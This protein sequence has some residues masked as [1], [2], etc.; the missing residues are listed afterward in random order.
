MIKIVQGC[1]TLEAHYSFLLIM[2]LFDTTG[3][4]TGTDTNTSIGSSHK[5]R[6]RYISEILTSLQILPNLLVKH[7][8]L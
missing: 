8:S 7:S 4:C 5:M 3:I 1:A 6:L 2:I